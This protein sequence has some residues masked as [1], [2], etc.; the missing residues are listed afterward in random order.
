MNEKFALGFHTCVDYELCWNTKIIE[1]QIIRYR[2]AAAELKLDIPINSERDIWIIS[3]AHLKEGIGWEVIPE[4]SEDCNTFAEHF[5]FTVTMGGTPTR[6]A[7]ILERFGY[8]SILQTS[9]YN[10]Y[11]TAL[12][13]KKIHVVP[14]KN[15]HD[16]VI[17]PHVVLQCKKG[18]IIRATDID[19]TQP[20]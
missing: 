6:A 8:S 10:S 11:V 13:P 1:E 18:I 19:L 15:L 14:G 12:L 4:H 9:C 20:R 5:D 17:Y 7:I 16:D 3:L 2:I